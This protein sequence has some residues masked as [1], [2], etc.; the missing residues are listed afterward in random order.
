MQ[1]FVLVN[2]DSSAIVL[3]GDRV[4]FVDGHFYIRT[5]TR[6]RLVDRVVHRLVDQMM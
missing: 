1:F 5:I 6:H 3:H 2:R 4:V